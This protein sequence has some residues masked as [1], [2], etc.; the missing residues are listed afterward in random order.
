M[1]DCDW[2]SDV[3][4]SDLSVVFTGTYSVSPNGRAAVTLNIGGRDFNFAMYVVNADMVILTSND[5]VGPGVPA[6]VGHAWR[7]T[8][9]PFSA[10]SLQGDYVFDLA[11]RNASTSA[12]ATVGRL[13]STGNNTASG[14][15]DR[16]D[17]YAITLGGSLS[18]TY[19][20]EA[21]GRGTLGSAQLGQ[22]IFYLVDDHKAILMESPN[23]RVQTGALER[24]QAAPYATANLIGQFSQGTAPPAALNSMTVTARVVYDG[25]GTESSTQVHNALLP[26][27][28][29]GG[30]TTAA[31]TVAPNGR[32]A[33]TDSLGNPLAAAYLV[34]P[35][36]YALVLQRPSGSACD[37]VVQ[38]NRAEQ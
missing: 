19:T 15:Y 10:A 6:R 31:Y 36:R 33:I 37:E 7:Q 11:G 1:L 30:S 23:G 3:C 4:S 13:S 21:S 20:I 18:A 17:N 35:G 22:W 12:I 29:A 32:L 28:L 14:Q 26:C 8:G 16:N 38:I 9:A 27:G 24:Q 34:D 2:S 5:D 25:A